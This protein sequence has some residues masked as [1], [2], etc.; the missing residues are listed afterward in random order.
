[1]LLGILERCFKN[2]PFSCLLFLMQ[3]F[4]AVYKG[5]FSQFFSMMVHY[6]IMNIAPCTIQ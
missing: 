3:L 4:S 5:V 1:M 2:S 6:R